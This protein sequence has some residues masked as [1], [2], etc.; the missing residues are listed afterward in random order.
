MLHGEYYVDHDNNNYPFIKRRNMKTASYQKNGKSEADWGF[1]QA[2]EGW[3]LVEW[4]EEIAPFRKDGVEQFD[5]NGN[6]KYIIP[7]LIKDDEDEGKKVT[8]FVNKGTKYSE[9]QVLDIL[10]ASGIEDHFISKYPGDVSIFDPNP[11]FDVL[12]MLPGRMCKV[13]LTLDKTGKYLNV[14]GIASAGFAPTQT[15]LAPASSQAA[16]GW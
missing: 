13:K 7:G 9:Q 15:V 5:K 16:K 6:A 12:K 2:A 10:A 3:H 14:D 11:W 8:I 4:Q 1:Q